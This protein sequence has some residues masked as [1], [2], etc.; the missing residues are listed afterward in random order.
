MLKLNTTRRLLNYCSDLKFHFEIFRTIPN[1]NLKTMEDETEECRKAASDGSL[2]RLKM[3]RRL[4]FSWDKWTCAMAAKNGH[5]D[6]LKYAYEHGCPWDFNTCLYAAKYGH[7]EIL[8]YAH[9]NGCILNCDAFDVAAK[10]GQVECLTYLLE[11]KCPWNY[12]ARNYAARNGHLKCLQLIVK[13]CENWDQSETVSLAA[14]GGH[15][16]C[17]RYLHE[18]NFRLDSFS[19]Q[20]AIINRRYHCI[21]YFFEKSCPISTSTIQ[22]A[23]KIGDLNLVKRLSSSPN[24]WAYFGGHL[25]TAAG[26]GYL[27]IIKYLVKEKNLYVSKFA[28]SE[29]AKNGHLKCLKWFKSNNYG[30]WT[31]NS[32]LSAAL[33]GHLKCLKFLFNQKCPWDKRTCAIAAANGHLECLRYAHQNKCP[34]DEKVCSLA[35]LGNHLEILEYARS[36]NC[37]WDQETIFNG[38]KAGHLGIIS[39]AIK[40]NCPMGNFPLI[41]KSEI[42]SLAALEGNLE[43]LEYLLKECKIQWIFDLKTSVTEAAKRGHFHIVKF[44]FQQNYDIWSTLICQYAALHGNLSMLRYAHENGCPWDDE[45]CDEAVN[46]SNLHCLKY[47][48]HNDCPWKRDLFEKAV[49]KRCL[50]TAKWIYK[51]FPNFSLNELN[52]T[53][54]LTSIMDDHLVMFQWLYSIGVPFDSKSI[55]LVDDYQSKNIQNW[56][57]ENIYKTEY[58]SVDWSCIICCNFKRCIALDPCGHVSMCMMCSKKVPHCPCCRSVIKQRLRIY[59]P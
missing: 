48:Y 58:C 4:N 43:C 56:L 55:V 8:K 24:S 41:F 19:F 28:V 16:D 1:L 9:E 38:V 7:L 36:E 27:H 47:A 15:L 6:L 42:C 40:N 25:E 21:E 33:N 52:E 18:N 31:E 35:A 12:S 46:N 45:T 26:S 32:T 13:H 54:Y 20:K 57:K 59:F 22:A 5:F 37:P 50:T 23:I 10:Y 51:N 2:E 29:A 3:L 11:K 17:V 53:Y 34:W 39:F 49:K 30:E 14:S 44:A